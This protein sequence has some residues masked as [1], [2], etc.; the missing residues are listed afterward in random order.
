MRGL[1]SWFTVHAKKQQTVNNTPNLMKFYSWVNYLYLLLRKIGKA[2]NCSQLQGCLYSHSVGILFCKQ[3]FFSASTDHFSLPC[4]FTWRAAFLLAE[5]SQSP[6]LQLFT[7]QILIQTDVD[8]ASGELRQDYLFSERGCCLLWG[9]KF[10][11]EANFIIFLK[12]T[13]R[14]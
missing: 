7:I 4:A 5:N 14:L 8:I 10:Q 11:Q 13:Q 12:T 1:S 3:S 2:F 6:C 9:V